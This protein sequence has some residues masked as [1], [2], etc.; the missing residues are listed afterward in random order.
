[1]KEGLILKET[2]ASSYEKVHIYTYDKMN[3]HKRKVKS[4]KKVPANHAYMP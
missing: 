1:M 2:D 4:K 3:K